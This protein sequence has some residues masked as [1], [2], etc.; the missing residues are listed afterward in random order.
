VILAAAMAGCG[1]SAPYHGGASWGATLPSGWYRLNFSESAG[2]VVSAGV[3]ISNV[4]LQRPTL[5][6]G[7]PV[8]VRDSELPADGVALDVATGKDPPVVPNGRVAAMPLPSPSASG[9]IIG[10]AL[11]GQPYLETLTFRANGKIFVA[12]LKVGS[13]ASGSTLKALSRIVR[14]LHILT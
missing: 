14:S 7:F 12:D 10:S 8:Q 3:Q 11:G 5:M 6:P 13:A 9:W 1:A 2:K 4:P